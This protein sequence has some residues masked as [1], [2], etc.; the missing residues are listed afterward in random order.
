ML[1]TNK[2]KAVG[3]EE[4]AEAMRWNER[5][6]NPETITWRNIRR[7]WQAYLL[8]LPIFTLLIIFVYYPPIL[9]LFRAFFDWRV[10]KEPVFVGLENFKTYFA[11]PDTPLEVVNMFKLLYWGILTSVVVPFFMA[12]LIFAIRSISTKELYRFLVVIPM[13]VPGVVFTL[14]WRHLYDPALGPINGLLEVTGLG[15]LARNW[16]GDPDTAL[17]AIIFVGFPWVATTN[18][19]IYLGGLAQ[20]SDSVFDACLLDGCSG[21]TRIVLVDIPL[22]LGQVRLLMILAGINALTAFNSVLILTRGGPGY[23]TSVPGFRMYERAFISGE[24]G[25]GSAIGL[26][27]FALAMVLT[28]TINKAIRPVIE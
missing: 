15:F 7:S 12:E 14:L 3:L 2:K 11:N 20:I 26:M 6:T 4:Q 17:Y 23:S 16:L 13:L 21:F 27:L 24:F 1:I 25:Y 5:V 22:V 18:T 19:L 9:G 28:F 10:A 8:L